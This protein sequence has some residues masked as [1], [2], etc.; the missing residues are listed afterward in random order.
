MLWGS[1]EPY[2]VHVASQDGPPKVN[3]GEESASPPEV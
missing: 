3:L 1:R 2:L